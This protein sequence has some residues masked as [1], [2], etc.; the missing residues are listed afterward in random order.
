MGKGYAIRTALALVTGDVIIIQDA[1]LEYN[2]EEYLKLIE[3]IEKG[4]AEVVYGS[5]ILGRKFRPVSFQN[6]IFYLGGRSLS[7]LTNFLYSE[8]YNRC[9]HLL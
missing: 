5:R 6:F 3:P 4:K 9:I 7:L 1:D 8:Q 2:P